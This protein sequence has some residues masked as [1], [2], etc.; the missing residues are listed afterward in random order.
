LLNTP[1][2]YEFGEGAVME[3]L[4]QRERWGAEHDAGKEPQDWYWL[5]A[6]LAGKALRACIDGNTEKALHHTISSAAVLANWHSH[7]LGAASEF[8][9][10]ISAEKQAAVDGLEVER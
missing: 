6:Y 8:R 3:A 5:L 7:I 1:V 4:H 9:P 2:L 10:G